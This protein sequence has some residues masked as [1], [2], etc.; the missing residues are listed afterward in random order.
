MGAAVGWIGAGLP[1]EG[2]GLIS[3]GYKIS[4]HEPSIVQSLAPK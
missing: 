1:S 4:V 2:Q 3:D